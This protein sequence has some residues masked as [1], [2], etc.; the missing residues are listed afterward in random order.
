MA[1]VKKPALSEEK[2][3]ELKEKIK[4]AFALFD[5][6]DKGC[7]VQEEVSTIM[8]YLGVFPSE[9]R[10]VES[11]LPDM[12]GDEPAL[13]VMYDKFEAKMLDILENHEDEPD[14]DDTLLRAF[15]AIDTE[16]LGYVEADYMKDLLEKHGTPFRAKEVDSF[17]SRAKDMETGRM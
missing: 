16:G 15:R 3:A 10:V 13:Y 9:R 2:V 11:I 12:Q 4:A 6:E 7:V 17:L 14:M 8:R 5:K 1:E